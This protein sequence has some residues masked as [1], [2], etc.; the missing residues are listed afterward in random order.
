MNVRV[1]TCI[2]IDPPPIGAAD[3]RA[4]PKPGDAEH[5]ALFH[6]TPL[7]LRP[8][9][10]RSSLTLRWTLGLGYL[11]VDRG[12]R[13]ELPSLRVRPILTEHALA[14]RTHVDQRNAEFL[15]GRDS[16]NQFISQKTR[17]SLR[18][19]MAVDGRRVATV[20]RHV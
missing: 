13:I 1:H 16:R 9:P 12:R 5:R 4:R 7:R 10:G 8:R 15:V 18:Q 19:P 14:G 6:A 11:P 20:E 17:R 2:R 3:E